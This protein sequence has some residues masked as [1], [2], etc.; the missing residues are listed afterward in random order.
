MKITREALRLIMR[1]VVSCCQDREHYEFLISLL[2]NGTPE[3]EMNMIREKFPTVNFYGRMEEIA[4]LNK[5]ILID[6]EDAAIFFG[7]REHLAK[8]KEELDGQIACGIPGSIKKKSFL[9]HF[10]LPIQ[11]GKTE[12]GTFV[13]TYSNDELTVVI[14]D[15]VLF[16]EDAGNISVGDMGIIHFASLVMHNPSASLVAHLLDEQR[17]MKEFMDIVRS[18]DGKTIR[19]AGHASVTNHLLKRNSL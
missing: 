4:Q 5:R 19:Q 11:L 17:K 6:E 7:G 1:T 3:F 2:K 12:K 18:V 10:H 15:I 8:V 9:L 14:K 13:G 16:K